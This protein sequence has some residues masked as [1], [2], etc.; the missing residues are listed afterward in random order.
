E[1]RLPRTSDL[2]S[3]GASSATAAQPRGSAGAEAAEPCRLRR[4]LLSV[5]RPQE[6]PAVLRAD[7]CHRGYPRQREQHS[8]RKADENG[9]HGHKLS[10]AAMAHASGLPRPRSSSQRTVAMPKVGAARGERGT[11]AAPS[12]SDTSATSN[13]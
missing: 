8:Q 11:R 4:K 12:L 2:R 7:P 13:E 5:L 10:V 6:S 3:T 1:S 9:V